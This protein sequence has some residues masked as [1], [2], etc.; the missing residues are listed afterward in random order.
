MPPPK[1]K[2]SFKRE[3]PMTIFNV[4][5]KVLV[6]KSMREHPAWVDSMD[7]WVGIVGVIRDSYRS[8]DTASVYCEANKDWWYFPTECLE[9]VATAPQEF[10]ITEPL[11]DYERF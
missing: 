10:T 7:E 8:S 6:K 4:G 11:Q 5:D 9:L 1:N 2:A 3:Q